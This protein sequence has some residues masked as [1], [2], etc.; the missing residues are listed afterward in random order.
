MKKFKILLITLLFSSINIFAF[1]DKVEV[2]TSFSD[3]Q[4]KDIEV[5]IR[6]YLLQNPEILFD[7]QIAYEVKAQVEQKQAMVDLA[8]KVPFEQY[9]SYGQL[10]KDKAKVIVYEFY[11]YNCVY[12]KSMTSTLLKILESDREVQI[13]TI[14]IPILSETSETAG[15]YSLALWSID[16]NLWSEFHQKLMGSKGFSTKLIEDFA[17]A[18]TSID[19]EKW[20]DLANSDEM[21]DLLNKNIELA[22]KIG[23]SGTPAYIIGE[24]FL[25]GAQSEEVMKEAIANAKSSN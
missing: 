16:K 20:N 14:N 6:N 10:A 2:K 18:N 4:V 22:Q 15:K 25:G 17:K 3:E 23:V 24:A 12:C 9:P 7:M 13:R 8:N 5:L 11:D 19:M 21:I 1:E